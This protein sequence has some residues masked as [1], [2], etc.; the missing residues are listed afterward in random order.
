MIQ[1]S[2]TLKYVGILAAAILLF[3]SS[4]GAQFNFL[5]KAKSAIGL[6]NDKYW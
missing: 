5:D 1:R 6:D 4:S 2:L 3:P